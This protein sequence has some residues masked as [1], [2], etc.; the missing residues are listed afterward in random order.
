MTEEKLKEVISLNEEI[1]RL[2]RVVEL[3]KNHDL[4][5]RPSGSEE[6][7]YI[8]K[9]SQRYCTLIHLF[10]SDLREMEKKFKLF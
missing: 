5:I 8:E 10:E 1:K 9:G 4:I 6:S 3:L 7:L 2:K